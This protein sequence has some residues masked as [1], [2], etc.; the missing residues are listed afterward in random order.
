MSF[1][2]KIKNLNSITGISLVTG[3]LYYSGYL[4]TEFHNK[5]LGIA[6]EYPAIEYLKWGGDFVIYSFTDFVSNIP[7]V[8]GTSN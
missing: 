2:D 3:I 6:I 1:I 8:L 4:S 5:I 7:A